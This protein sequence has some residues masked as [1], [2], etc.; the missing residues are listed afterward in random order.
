MIYN[1]EEIRENIKQQAEWTPRVVET[2]F[3][4]IL[5][6]LD[7][8]ELRRIRNVYLTGCGDS[9]IAGN[10]MEQLFLKVSGLTARSFPALE[11]ARYRVAF[12][13][14]PSV[15]LAIS[16]S[17]KVSRT[18]EATRLARER[19]LLTI[20]ISRQDVDT[21]LASTANCVL[22][23]NTPVTKQII[24]GCLSYLASLLAVAVFA[25]YLGE[26]RGNITSHFADKL[27]GALKHLGSLIP[28]TMETS[29]AKIERFVE[30][31][32]PNELWHFLVV[33][34][35]MLLRNMVP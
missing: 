30:S 14:S 22:A 23:L 19:R 29:R 31:A 34:P 35:I 2:V 10:A 12:A 15:L 32:D 11:F 33:D 27:Y 3:L 13:E 28:E 25:I 24:P 26:A 6:K 5:N 20:G 9:R 1:Y 8:A 17:G 18:I 4:Q 21:P 16:Y 7:I